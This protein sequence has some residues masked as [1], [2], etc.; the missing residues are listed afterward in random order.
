LSAV[1]E[2]IFDPVRGTEPLLPS[3]YVKV[4]ESEGDIEDG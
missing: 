3:K 4:K 1:K 2:D